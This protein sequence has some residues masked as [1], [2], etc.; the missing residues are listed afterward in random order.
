MKQLTQSL[1]LLCLL[2][3]CFAA[4]STPEV[5]STPLK[6]VVQP[7]ATFMNATPGVQLFSFFSSDAYKEEKVV[8]KGMACLTGSYGDKPAVG[9]CAIEVDGVSIKPHFLV[10]QEDKE[11]LQAALKKAEQDSQGNVESL[12]III[13]GTL[14]KEGSNKSPFG[15]ELDLRFANGKLLQ[16]QE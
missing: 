1:A 8:V 10:S 7:V 16:I 3:G 9:M 11:T 2:L 5:P 12:P 13:E 14:I 4:C 6:E 15:G